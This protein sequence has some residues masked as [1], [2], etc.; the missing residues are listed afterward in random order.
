MHVSELTMLPPL[1]QM[2][3][4][5]KRQVELTSLSHLACNVR[6]S[7]EVEPRQAVDLGLVDMDMP[8]PIRWYACVRE[9]GQ[10]RP[11][12]V[13]DTVHQQMCSQ[14]EWTA[15]CFVVKAAMIMMIRMRRGCSHSVIVREVQ[16]GRWRPSCVVT[17]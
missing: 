4:S 15:R 7:L 14:V 13:L 17:Q 11:F 12:E 16:V 9:Y 3:V 5:E 1:L 10:A 2:D 6:A 8:V